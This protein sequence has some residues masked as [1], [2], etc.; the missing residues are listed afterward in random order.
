M[1]SMK[2]SLRSTLIGLALLLVTFVGGVLAGVAL[3]RTMS[4]GENTLRAER[5]VDGRDRQPGL[6]RFMDQLD[7]TQAQQDEIA[8]ILQRGHSETRTFW[9]HEGSHLRAIVDSTR[10]EIRAVLTPEQREEYDAFRQRRAQD[11]GAHS[12]DGRRR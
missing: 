4:T 7:L 9:E 2:T 8:I 1:L 11:R 6:H 5:P 10:A 12:E 3:E